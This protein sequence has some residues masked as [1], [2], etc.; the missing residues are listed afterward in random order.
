MHAR[1]PMA[2]FANGVAYL[3]ASLFGLAALAG[4]AQARD[5]FLDG[6]MDTGGF[7]G[8]EI[9]YTEVKDQGAVMIGGKGAGVFGNDLHAFY[10]GGGGYGLVSQAELSSTLEFDFGYGGLILGYTRNPDN[11]IHFEFEALLGGGGVVVSQQNSLD[12]QDEA[13][14]LVAE[15]TATVE[16]NVTDFLQIGVGAFYRQVSDPNIDGLS[17]AD[18]SGLGVAMD[19]EFGSFH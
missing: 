5:N 17:A 1:K 14:V 13:A 15:V 8:P 4:T 11:L 12:S 16:A 10:I 3:A 2:V 9:R 19:F 7:G 18:L 6:P